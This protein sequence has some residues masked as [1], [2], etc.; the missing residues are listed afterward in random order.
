M[1]CE[2]T[3]TPNCGQSSGTL[4]VMTSEQCEDVLQLVANVSLLCLILKTH[5]CLLRNIKL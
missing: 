2:Q 3:P 5:C 4:G 1:I